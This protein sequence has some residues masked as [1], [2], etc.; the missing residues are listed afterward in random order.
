MTYLFVGQLSFANHDVRCRQIRLILVP[1]LS[2]A[3]GHGLVEVFGIH[4][5]GHF[6]GLSNRLHERLAHNLVLVDSDEASLGLGGG[7]KDCVDS[8]YTLEGRKHPVICHGGSTSLDVAKSCDASVE[9]QPTFALVGE[10]VLDF[11]RGDLGSI[12]VAGALGNDDNGLS[13]APITML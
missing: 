2:I 8:L 13:L 3:E 4:S 1:K 12:S 5:L 11:V 10:K 9:G 6:L 7:L